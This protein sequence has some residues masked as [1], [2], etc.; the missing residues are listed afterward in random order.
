MVKGKYPGREERLTAEGFIGANSFYV[1]SGLA[2]GNVNPNT[3]AARSLD[4][5]ETKSV[6]N[7]RAASRPA[8]AGGGAWQTAGSGS[9]RGAAAGALA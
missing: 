2:S 4:P 6:Q 3:G 5:L 9:A 8:R 7:P 1:P